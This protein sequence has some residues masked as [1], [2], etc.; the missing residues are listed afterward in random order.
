MQFVIYIG[1]RLHHRGATEGYALRVREGREEE[2]T[3]QEP[4]RPVLNHSAGKI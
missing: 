3:H 2:G 1:A 4:G